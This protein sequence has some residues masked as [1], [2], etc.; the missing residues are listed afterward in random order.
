MERVNLFFTFV[1]S[2]S[3]FEFH[4]A[5]VVQLA[6]GC[7]VNFREKCQFFGKVYI[8]IYM[9]RSTFQR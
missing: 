3:K 9:S 7:Y 4:E 1:I 8:Y 5:K 6:T 2:M